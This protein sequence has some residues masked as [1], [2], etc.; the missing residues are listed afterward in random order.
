MIGHVFSREAAIYLKLRSAC[1]R[2]LWRVHQNSPS[3]DRFERTGHL[4]QMSSD[5]FAL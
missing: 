2:T 1:P 4:C 5:A 3:K